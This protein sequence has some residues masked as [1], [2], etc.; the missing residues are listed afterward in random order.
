MT[1][2]SQFS[3]RDLA[4]IAEKQQLAKAL[5]RPALK[6]NITFRDS[7]ARLRLP[8]WDECTVLEKDLQPSVGKKP[9]S[10][11]IFQVLKNL[12][13]IVGAS[14]KLLSR[15]NKKAYNRAVQILYSKN[16]SRNASRALTNLYAHFAKHLEGFCTALE[17]LVLDAPED[18][19][20]VVRSY[21]VH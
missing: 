18:V 2:G 7:V 21:E 12:D 4:T 8:T 17:E 5:D 11:S 10:Y 14:P 15:T 6:V 20:L 16:F 1:A 13:L 9:Y 3:I 19:L